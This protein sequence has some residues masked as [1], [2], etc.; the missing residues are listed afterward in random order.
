VGIG[1]SAGGLEALTNLFAPIPCTKQLAFVVIQHLSPHF[2]SVMRELLVKKT[3]LKVVVAEQDMLI[4]P[5]TIYLNRPLCDLEVKDGRLLLREWEE[6]AHSRR[7]RFPIDVLFRSLAIEDG[8]RAIGVVLSGTGSDGSRGLAAIHEVGGLTVVQK[9]ETAQ[10]EGMPDAASR[11]TICNLVLIPED[12]GEALLQHLSNPIPADISGDI[13]TSEFDNLAAIRGLLQ[14]SHGLLLHLYKEPTVQRR[15][16]RRIALLGLKSITEYLTEL[17]S[18]PTEVEALYADLLIGVTR[19]F[20]DR[21]AFE[22][23]E[24]ALSEAVAQ[25]AGEEFRVWIPACATGEE[26]YSV[27]MLLHERLAGSRVKVFATDLHQRSIRVASQ[28]IYDEVALSEVSPE[29]QKRFF[30]AVAGGFQVRKALRQSV[31]FATHDLLADPPFS[32]VDLVCCRNLLI[33]FNPEGQKQ[34][35]ARLVYALKLGG[36]L[37]LGPSESIGAQVKALEEVDSRWKLFRKERPAP[38]HGAFN[39]PRASAQRAVLTTPQSPWDPHLSAYDALLAEYAPPGLLVDSQRQLLHTFGDGHRLL[40]VRPGRPSRD[41]LE[42]VRGDLRVPLSAALHRAIDVSV[43]GL[44]AADVPGT[45]ERLQVR[46]LKSRAGPVHFLITVGQAPARSE[47]VSVVVNTDQQWRASVEQELLWTRRSLQE[48]KETAE[49]ANEELQAT[50]EELVAANE[51]LQ[52]TNEELQS[53]NSEFRLQNDELLSATADLENLLRSTDIGVVF[54]DEQLCVRKFTER[55]VEL[56]HLRASDVGR[57]LDEL[58]TTAAHRK[59]LELARAVLHEETILDEEVC[60]PDDRYRLLQVR[61]YLEEIDLKG[62]VLSFIDTTDLR[63][64]QEQLSLQ[65]A[66]LDIMAHGVGIWRLEDRDD[67]GSFRFLYANAASDRISGLDSGPLLGKTA[68]EA[69]PAALEAGVFENYR[70]VVLTGAPR[71]DEFNHADP[72]SRPNVVR[73]I[74]S[75]GPNDTV[76]VVFED[77]SED[78]ARRQ[79]AEAARRL[80]SIGEVSGS[81]A[82]DLNNLLSVILLNLQQPPAQLP[83]EEFLATRQA[84]N[85]AADLVAQ[86]LAYS[87]RRPIS[88]RAVDPGGL[89]ARIQPVLLSVLGPTNALQIQNDPDLQAVRIDPSA[90]EQVLINL[91]TNTRNALT[92]RDGRVTIRTRNFSAEAGQRFVQLEFSDDGPGMNP[93]VQARCFEPFFSTQPKG[94]GTGLGLSSARGVIE[95]AGGRIWVRSAPEQGAT[96]TIQL[97]ALDGPAEAPEPKTRPAWRGKGQRVLVV[98]DEAALCR[99]TKRLLKGLGL[100]AEAAYRGSEALEWITRNGPPDLLLTDVLMPD[101]NGPSLAD[102]VRARFPKLPVLFMSGYPDHAGVR[103]TAWELNAHNFLEKPFDLQQLTAALERLLESDEAP[104]G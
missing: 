10:F 79:E 102:E 74:A 97:P 56:F 27:A 6:D 21:E 43:Q 104:P 45:G 44:I 13:A 75:P 17:R 67:P 92:G 23:L 8:A 84:A 77:I 71:T 90:M 49:T 4:E 5:D 58:A 64:A 62:V 73:Q 38:A 20:R 12:V 22:V 100:Q 55:A 9:P 47:A 68:R 33:Y 98:D 39:A 54:L 1:A 103:N 65:S 46:P 86:L 28:G 40:Q 48:A 29:R 16:T 70:Q 37:F 59:A 91:A 81:I 80:Q 63:A 72:R 76:V 31:V 94:L 95:Q 85:R 42:L 50:N 14:E 26:A 34:A 60:F 11:A 36:L 83:H 66:V 2:K 89:V 32:Q 24:T 101:M 25:R 41:V 88:P 18:N 87:K 35:L 3:E 99:A 96:F 82:H 93:E 53:V 19:F 30:E 51:E 15:V 69:A 57:P 78:I 7:P 52:S 61:P